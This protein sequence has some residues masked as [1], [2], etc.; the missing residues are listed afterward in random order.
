MSLAEDRVLGRD[1]EDCRPLDLH[2]RD[3]II[4]KCVMEEQIK[5]IVLCFK[6]KNLCSNRAFNLSIH[7]LFP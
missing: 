5:A 1:Y 4:G 6:S 7:Y 2:A 3:Q